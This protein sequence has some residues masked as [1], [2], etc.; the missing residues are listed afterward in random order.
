MKDIRLS[1][2]YK[3]WFK[4]LHSE[5]CV[6]KICY[7]IMYDKCKRSISPVNNWVSNIK[8][9]LFEI[10][11]GQVWCEQDYV[12]FATHYPQQRLAEN[13]IQNLVEQINFSSRCHFYKHNYYRSFFFTIL[14]LK[15]MFINSYN[16]KASI[17]IKNCIIWGIVST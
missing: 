14:L 1:R 7:D 6:L 17:F 8:H 2:N 10:G 16:Y 5:K 9:E 12:H 13:F 4:L 3:Y 15:I 11:L